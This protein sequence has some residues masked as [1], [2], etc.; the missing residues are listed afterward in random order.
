[1]V[2]QISYEVTLAVLW[3]GAWLAPKPCK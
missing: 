3:R 2:Q 1:M